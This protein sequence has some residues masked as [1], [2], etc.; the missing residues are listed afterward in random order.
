MGEITLFEVIINF[1]E[2][3]IKKKKKTLKKKIPAKKKKV[4]SIRL[5][6]SKIEPR[7]L[8]EIQLQMNDLIEE[9]RTKNSI[10]QE[11]QRQLSISNEVVLKMTQQVQTDLQNLYNL[12]ENLIP[13]YFPNIPDC[14][15]SYK[16]VSSLQGKGKD[17]YQIIPLHRMHFGL[18][19]SSCVSHILSSLLFSSR[20]RLMARTDYK[21]LQPAEVLHELIKEIHQQMKGTQIET[22]VDIF[23]AIVNQKKYHLS[24]C[25]IGR[26]CSLLYSFSAKELHELKSSSSYFNFED[27]ESLSNKKVELNPRDHLI[28]CS[29]GVIECKND[30]GEMY[31]LD[32]L[33]EVIKGFKTPGAH[34]L[35][36]RIMY[37]I[38]SFTKDKGID[39]DQSIIVMEIRDRILKLT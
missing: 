9:V 12:H 32:R 34:R 2:F 26:I 39:R 35:R 5:K 29:P 6:T 20:L 1:C 16:F 33:K 37:S 13:T 28:V 15:F 27:M 24:Y 3:M 11:Y 7:T 18:V 19:M 31:G 38:R 25:S 17:F 8:K 30:K 36:N 10:I 4:K 14:E 23:Y 22:K 21:K